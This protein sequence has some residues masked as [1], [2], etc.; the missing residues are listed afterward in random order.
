VL[1]VAVLAAVIAFV[2]PAA[3][4]L[5]DLLLSHPLHYATVLKLR[6]INPSVEEVKSSTGL[7]HATP[8]L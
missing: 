1:S 4:F 6:R 2:A 5:H 7:R 8:G 3:K